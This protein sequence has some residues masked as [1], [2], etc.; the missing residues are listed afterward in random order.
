MDLERAVAGAD[1]HTPT[2]NKMHTQAN[3]RLIKTL[4]FT[5]GLKFIIA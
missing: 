4:L 2:I 3:K 1:S 5:P